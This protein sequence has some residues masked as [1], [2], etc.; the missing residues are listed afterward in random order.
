MKIRKN[1]ALEVPWNQGQCYLHIYIIQTLR[2][3]SRW[4]CEK[5]VRKSTCYFSD[6]A[7]VARDTRYGVPGEDAVIISPVWILVPSCMGRVK[8]DIPQSRS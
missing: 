6:V 5:G 3:V 4:F 2:A 8:V 1:A 7:K